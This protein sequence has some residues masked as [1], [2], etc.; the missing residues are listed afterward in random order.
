MFKTT[1]NDQGKGFN[2]EEWIADQKEQKP[3]V[4]LVDDNEEILDYLA[5]DLKSRYTVLTA[6]DGAEALRVLDTAFVQ[7]IVSD[8]MMPH[9]DGFA[10][11]EKIRSSL[12]FNH[13]PLILLTAKDTLQSKIQGLKTGADAYIE[14]PFSLEHLY[15]QI[16]NL[17]ENRARLKDFYA[18]SPLAHI[19][20]MA[21]SKM[22]QDFLENLHGHIVRNL[23]DAGLD[24]EKLALLMNVSRPTLYRKIKSIS[25]LAPHD[26]INLTRLKKA[27]ILINEGNLRI[28]EVAELV[29]YN[30]PS[31]F[32]RNFLKQ[33]KISPTAYIDKVTAAFNK[34]PEDE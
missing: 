14:K 30:S 13:I 20:S 8:V 23:E 3:V 29:G 7:L 2:M 31:Q 28:N 24:V 27:A 15:V 11:C 10:F 32:K 34:H 19:N 9:I 26:I 22:D 6:H 4:L 25:G 5:G 12:E 1:K 18:R 33:F 16:E 21:H 17:L